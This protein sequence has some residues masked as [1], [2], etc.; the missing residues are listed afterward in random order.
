[1]LTFLVILISGLQ[2]TVKEGMWSKVTLEKIWLWVTSLYP[3]VHPQPSLHYLIESV[4]LS[5]LS[6]INAILAALSAW[7][8]SPSQSQRILK[9][10]YGIWILGGH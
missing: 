4:L 1:M 9:R 10:H 2:E 5:S 3:H 7:L 6:S 8:C